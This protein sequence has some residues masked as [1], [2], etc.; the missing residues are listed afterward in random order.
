MVTKLIHRNSVCLAFLLLCSLGALHAQKLSTF[1]ANGLY[2]YKNG[3]TVVIPPAYQYA[4][5]FHEGRAAVLL[6]K[7][8]G[9]IDPKGKL[10]IPNDMEHAES[11]NY[12]FA[13]FYQNG[14][15]GLMDT[16]GKQIVPAICD[17][18]NTWDGNRWEFSSENN[19]GIY[20]LESHLYI[21]PIYKSIDLNE[22]FIV[23]ETPKKS[24]DVYLRNPDTE[25]VIKNL[26]QRPIMTNY[27]NT[28][29][30]DITINGKT[31]IIDESGRKVSDVYNGISY[32]NVNVDHKA[33]ENSM[34]YDRVYLLQL[35]D[36][37]ENTIDIE[38]NEIPSTFHL[39]FDENYRFTDAIY[40][41]LIAGYS[42][43]DLKKNGQKA[44]LN[45]DGNL[46]VS[47][48]YDE[49]IFG[50]YA[51]LYYE[52]QSVDVAKLQYSFNA[53]L[54]QTDT[55]VKY[56]FPGVE[57]LR[58]N[59]YGPSYSTDES[60]EFV[61]MS[62]EV[63]SLIQVQSESGEYALFHLDRGIYLTP[64]S[65]KRKSLLEYDD[66]NNTFVLYSE[67][68]GGKYYSING[69]VSEQELVDYEDLNNYYAVTYAYG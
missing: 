2:G 4:A 35:N 36:D 9:Y 59:N 45:E 27:Y 20:L 26:D 52:N 66:D 55:V 31:V 1:R 53:D 67:E 43:F 29:Y 13:R 6:N 56:H 39:F 3:E 30:C 68:D 69:K 25:T 58:I 23:C 7:K 54:T 60:G 18:I 37:F 40:S 46:I 64:F 33:G 63:Q 41:D 42:R 44:Y 22:N 12:G 47:K 57:I 32:L 24:F 65:P 51:L 15:V 49:T 14:K 28:I 34:Y 11:F 38:G 48:Y 50:G 19:K 5:D 21:P 62:E 17:K 10:I 61:D 16:M 8:W